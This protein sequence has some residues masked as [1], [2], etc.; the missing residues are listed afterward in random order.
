MLLRYHYGN[1]ER[2]RIFADVR[3]AGELRKEETSL[4]K[5]HPGRYE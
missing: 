1:A 2:N 3:F 5:D 4:P